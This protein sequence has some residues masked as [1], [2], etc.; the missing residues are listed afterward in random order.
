MSWSFKP[1]VDPSHYAGVSYDSKER[2]ISYWHQI[3]EVAS[4]RPESVL[5][6]GIGNGFV[7]RSLREL[8]IGVHTVDADE[9]LAP[10][11]VAS[12]TALPFSAG[13]F[14]IGCCFETLEHLPWQQFAS[15]VSEL[16]R[17]A[18]SYVLLSLPDVT[19]CFRADLS[20]GLRRR[21]L[22]VFCDLPSF[23]AE[24]HAFNGEHY[25]EVGKRGYPQARI[26]H[27]FERAGLGVER[28]FRVRENPYH[29]F[30]RLKPAR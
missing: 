16:A 28:E 9:R 8:G 24:L 26:R 19:P 20:W 22:S 23:R 13:E 27:A 21:L 29:H 17:V 30:F 3:H 7:H 10:D 18:R 11:T 12:V 2:F 6:V 15:A 1:Q 5:E 25:W 4:L 14:E